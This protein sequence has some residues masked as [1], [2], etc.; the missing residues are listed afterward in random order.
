MEW[1][2]VKLDY[3]IYT[4]SH[5]QMTADVS[6]YLLPADFGTMIFVEW[7]SVRLLPSSVFEWQRDGVDYRNL[8]SALPFEYAVRGRSLILKPPPSSAALD[9]DPFLTIQYI[10]SAAMLDSG[11]TPQLSNLDQQL[12]ILR[13]AVR[14]CR[15]HPSEENAFKIQG[16]NDEIVELLPA[17]RYRAQN[18]IEE[19]QPA[20]QPVVDRFRGAR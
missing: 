6:E 14:Y 11:G 9:T 4:D 20:V 3:S 15:T 13:A 10:G 5:F 8:E 17:A 16:Y 18:A 7:S 19:Y 2:A 1:L 12:L